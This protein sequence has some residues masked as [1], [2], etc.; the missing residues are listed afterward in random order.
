MTYIQ[1]EFSHLWDDRNEEV[2]FD[3]SQYEE[4]S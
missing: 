2:P 1:E 4:K 3:L